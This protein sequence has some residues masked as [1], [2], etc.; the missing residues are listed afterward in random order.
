MGVGETKPCAWAA[1]RA[2]HWQGAAWGGSSALAQA[3]VLRLQALKPTTSVVA[4]SLAGPP[5]SLPA[6]HARRHAATSP[7]PTLANRQWPLHL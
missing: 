2:Q 1:W 3:R 6:P 4:C 5:S 7:T